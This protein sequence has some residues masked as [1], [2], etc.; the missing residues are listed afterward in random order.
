MARRHATRPGSS[1][2]IGDDDT[3]SIFAWLRIDPTGEAP[4]V[5]AVVNATP[6]VHHGYRIGVPEAGRGTE[7]LNSDAEIYGGSGK[8]NLGSVDAEDQRMARLRP[9]AATD[10]APA[11]RGRPAPR[12]G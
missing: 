4:P 3:H 7:L 8:G 5:M 10:R 11:R 12:R 2:I 6:A 1:W 9:L